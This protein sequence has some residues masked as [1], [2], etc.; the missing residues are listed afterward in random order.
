MT[1]IIKWLMILLSALMINCAVSGCAHKAVQYCPKP[2]KPVLQDIRTD[3]D[4]L[5][6]LNQ[7]VDYS[8]GLES[9][10]KCYEVR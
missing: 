3:K 5:D 2:A 8:K 1:N 10:L 7:C 9:T 4:M 6:A